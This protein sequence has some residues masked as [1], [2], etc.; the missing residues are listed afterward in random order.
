MA[1]KKLV[2]FRLHEDLL[3]GFLRAAKPFYGK[4]GLCYSAAILM[5][6][7]ADPESRGRYVSR[8]FAAET[9]DEVRETLATMHAEALTTRRRSRRARRKPT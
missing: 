9:A 5:F 1:R 4:L 2:S 7:E 8:V 6:L 3:D